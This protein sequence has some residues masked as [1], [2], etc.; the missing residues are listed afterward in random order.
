MS[1]RARAR[2]SLP[3][4][5]TAAAGFLIAYLVVAFVVFPTGLIPDDT[6]IPDVAGLTYDAAARRLAQSGFRARQGEMRYHATAPQGT[7]LSQRP[8]AGTRVPRNTVVTLDVSRGAE[9]AQVPPVAG[10]PRHLAQVTLRSAGLDVG[11]VTTRASTAPRGAVL[12]TAPAEGTQLPLAA[13]VNL[14]VSDGPARMAMP[15]VVGQSYV[16]A[17]ALLEQLGL[18]PGRALVDT[19][20]G[21]L[22]NTILAQ[23]PGAGEPVARGARVELHVAGRAP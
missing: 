11:Q 1:W 12:A 6:D 17:R 3:F 15:D 2:R 9:R 20:S 5:I 8:P 22:E 16:Q 18:R 19:T 4:L 21:Q 14:V 13:T 23:S 10:L 7:V